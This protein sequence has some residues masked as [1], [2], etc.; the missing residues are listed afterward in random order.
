[1]LNREAINSNFIV[2]GLIRGGIDR[3]N[4][5][6]GKYTNHYTMDA[7]ILDNSCQNQIFVV[8]VNITKQNAKINIFCI[9]D[10]VAY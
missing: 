2:I 8:F 3:T 4:D 9:L 10:K 1:M 7:T 6:Q 5:L